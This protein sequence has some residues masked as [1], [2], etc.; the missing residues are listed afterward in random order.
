[1]DK[2]ELVLFIFHRP[3]YLFFMGHPVV[4]EDLVPVVVVMVEP[5]M[6]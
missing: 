5:A 2:V 1:V 3:H 4:V 6:E